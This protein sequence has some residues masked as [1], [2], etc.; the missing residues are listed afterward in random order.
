ML[1]DKLF[2]V[3]ND[4]VGVKKETNVGVVCADRCRRG[5]TTNASVLR[6][7][8]KRWRFKFGLLADCRANR[9]PA[10]LLIDRQPPKRGRQP[11]TVVV[12]T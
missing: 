9:Q 3:D 4:S 8:T 5:V 11:N 1:T 12:Q 6:P 2:I 7:Y 10:L